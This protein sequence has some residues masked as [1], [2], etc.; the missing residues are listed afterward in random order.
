ME[1]PLVIIDGTK[2]TSKGWTRYKA[3]IG[4]YWFE[5]AGGPFRTLALLALARMRPGEDRWLDKS[6]ITQPGHRARQH[7]YELRQAIFR[8]LYC[9]K[10]LVDW[11]PV[12][13]DGGRRYCLNTRQRQVRI[14]N[15]E[16][17]REFGDTAVKEM[18][19]EVGRMGYLKQVKSEATNGKS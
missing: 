1:L 4:D 10:A 8:E 7:V 19:D 17:L 13:W 5:L 12:R 3:T 18:L 9:R 6:I 14:D 2:V 16:A 15:P 11:D